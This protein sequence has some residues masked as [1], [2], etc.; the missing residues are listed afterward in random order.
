MVSASAPKE[1]PENTVPFSN[2]SFAG[3][4]M[5]ICIYLVRDFCGQVIDIK[6][7]QIN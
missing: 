6:K 4:F 2:T 3:L 5:L 1:T 7:P